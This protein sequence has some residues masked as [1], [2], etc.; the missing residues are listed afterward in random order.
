MP[1]QIGQARLRSQRIGGEGV[2]I[3]QPIVLFHVAARHLPAQAEVQSEMARNA[4]VVLQ[5][6]RPI[7][8]L[9]GDRVQPIDQT[10]GHIAQQER[11]ES[12]TGRSAALYG[13]RSLG[14]TPAEGEQAG[15][16]VQLAFIEME[17]AILAAEFQAVGAA[18]IAQAAARRVDIAGLELQEIVHR[19]IGSANYVADGERGE[20]GDHLA[21]ECGHE[22]ERAHVETLR[23]AVLRGQCAVG[24]KLRVPYQRGRKDVGQIGH[25]LRVM[26]RS[27]PAAA[28]RQR[29]IAGRNP[30]VLLPREAHEEVRVLAEIHVRPDIVFVAVGNRFRPKEIIVLPANRGSRDVWQWIEAN[31]FC[32]HG[33]KPV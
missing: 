4:P 25:S 18:Q 20:L 31:S 10:A 32:R 29:H 24:R 3:R 21:G 16:I 5:K 12:E 15:G 30:V 6:T 13:I 27:L 33:V 26:I 17:P 2:E 1:L 22:T 8:A 11:R 19:V 23:H 9:G 7:T 28:D 14:V